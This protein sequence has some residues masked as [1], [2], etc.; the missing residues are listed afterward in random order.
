[1]Y[2]MEKKEKFLLYLSFLDIYSNRRKVPYIR[3]FEKW[4]INNTCIMSRLSQKLV[5][6]H[7]YFPH[8]SCGRMYFYLVWS[9]KNRE[10]T[11]YMKRNA[12]NLFTADGFNKC[13]KIMLSCAALLFII[14][15]V[16]VFEADRSAILSSASKGVRQIIWS[17]GGLL[18]TAFFLLVNY[19]KLA[20]EKLLLF[21]LVP[22]TAMLV[23]LALCSLIHL[24]GHEVRFSGAGLGIRRIN[25]AFRWIELGP[26]N[27]QPSVFVQVFLIL[28][29]AAQLSQIPDDSKRKAKSSAVAISSKEY[30]SSALIKYRSLWF[31]LLIFVLIFAQPSTSVAISVMVTALAMTALKNSKIVFGRNFFIIV[32]VILLAGLIAW[33][34]FPHIRERVERGGD[35]F[36]SRQAVLAIGSGG[37]LGLGLGN[38]EAK[39]SRLPEIENDY[40]FSLIAEETGFVGSVLFM[41]IYVVFILQGFMT[42]IRAKDSFAKLAAFGFSVNYAFAFLVHLFV[43]LG[44]ISTG[45]GLPFVSYGGTAMLADSIALGILL[46]ISGSLEKTSQERTKT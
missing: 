34:A 14:G 3:N 32:A 33:N 36:Q 46:N 38:S 42:A 5:L 15:V 31:S 45:A 17:A 35:N 10:E 23:I 4:Q 40:I 19:K 27:F 2:L 37:V 18:F 11:K 28:F 7:I 9:Y 24:F 16:F 29:I 43:N 6:L 39:H 12:E 21:F 30:V 44:F 13:N 22:L 26:L 25:G 41:G 1:M 20:S 8:S